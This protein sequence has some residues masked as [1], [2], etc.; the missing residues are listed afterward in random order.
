[1]DLWLLNRI[2]RG[3]GNGL[4]SRIREQ[5]DRHAQFLENVRGENGIEVKPNCA[6]GVTVRWSG[7]GVAEG[8]ASRWSG[9]V[10]FLGIVLY[11][12]N[13]A[14]ASPEGALIE[15]GVADAI[16]GVYLKFNLLTQEVTW[17]PTPPSSYSDAA[18]INYY[19][20]GVED[21]NYTTGYAPSVGRVVGD[22]RIDYVPYHAPIEEEIEEEAET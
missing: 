12:F 19:P 16:G 13:R 21:T 8:S 9:I 22:I 5:L 11:D 15:G 3:R 14:G 6:G 1:M 20:V 2:G 4:L 10:W 18:Y 17:S 7:G